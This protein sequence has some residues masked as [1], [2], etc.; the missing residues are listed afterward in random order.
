MNQNYIYIGGTQSAP[1]IS[2]TNE[3]LL[4]VNVNMNIDAIGNELAIDTLQFD[5]S[6]DDSSRRLRD[7]QYGTPIWYY[8]GADIVG[9]FYFKNIERI[10]TTSYRIDAVSVIGLLEYERHYGGFYVNKNVKEAVTEAIIND[11]LTVGEAQPCG[12]LQSNGNTPNTPLLPGCVGANA[13]VS[14][15]C[16][17]VRIKFQLD[18]VPETSASIPIWFLYSD[19]YNGE[20]ESDTQFSSYGIR[21]QR[22]GSNIWLYLSSNYFSWSPSLSDPYYD[23]ST[24]ASIGDLFEITFQPSAKKIYIIRNGAEPQII[25]ISWTIPNRIVPIYFLVG[26]EYRPATGFVPYTTNS[27]LKY[28]LYGIEYLSEDLLT[29]YAKFEP[30]A[31]LLGNAYVYDSIG[32]RVVEATGFSPSAITGRSHTF[33]EYASTDGTGTNAEFRT[34]YKGESVASSGCNTAFYLKFK[35]NA[36]TSE[37]PMAFQTVWKNVFIIPTNAQADEYRYYDAGVLLMRSSS[38]S[39]FSA[40]VYGTLRDVYNGPIIYLNGLS[41]GDVVEVAVYPKFG[42]AF[43]LV[44]GIVSYNESFTPVQS[45]D[46]ILPMYSLYGVNDDWNSN[47][48]SIETTPQG[49][50]GQFRPPKYSLYRLCF[51]DHDDSR[52]ASVEVQPDDTIYFDIE[53]AE[54]SL[55]GQYFHDKV[56]GEYF[57]TDYTAGGEITGHEDNTS[58]YEKVATSIVWQDGVDALT[59]SGWIPAGTKRATLHQILFALN[60]NL[61]KSGT[62]DIIIGRLPSSVNKTISD[63]DIYDS[64]S[65]E[66]VKKPKKIELTENAYTAPSSSADE[67][68]VFDN[69]A[70]TTP[71]GR[72]IAEFSSAPIYGTPTGSGLT[73][74]T[75]NA[76]AALV[77]GKGTIR[78]KTY[79]RSTRVITEEVGTRPDGDTVSVTDATLVTFLNSANVMAKLK[80]YYANN[81]Y[82]IKNAIVG[83]GELVG[84]KYTL[85]TPFGETDDAY[86]ISANIVGSGVSKINA[87]FLAG[88]TP[89]ES[90]GTYTNVV[91]LTG[92]GTWEVPSGTEQIH[93]VLIGG[94]RGGDSGFAGEDGDKCWEWRSANVAEGGKKGANGTGGKIYEVDIDVSSTSWSYS[95]G[96]GGSGGGTS[97]SNE[98]NNP[99]TNGTAS[100]FSQGG[101]SYSSDSGSSNEQGYTDPLTGKIYAGQMPKNVDGGNGGYT[102]FTSNGS[103]PSESQCHFNSPENVTNPL[104]GFVYFGGNTSVYYRDESEYDPSGYNVRVG[105]S[106]GGAALNE[107]G[108][109]GNTW[110]NMYGGNGADATWVPPA[111]TD[112]Q[113]E[114]YGYGG[115]GGAGGGGGGSTG[116]NGVFEGID[117][118]WLA[119][120][121]YPGTGGYGGRGGNGGNGCILVYW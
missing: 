115:M 99:G 7:L 117:E 41:A 51:F 38:S 116:F 71:E 82:K 48:H 76:N 21:V 15:K 20:S 27:G 54:D 84:R 96:L 67:T 69:S 63:D 44:N 36:P 72:Y 68:T 26:G 118:E 102:T 119:R 18:E 100:T 79:T 98:T 95:C 33:Y 13:T 61:Y 74:Y 46:R 104:S 56:S 87:V 49:P 34:G 30:Y 66:D 80:A 19:R 1:E 58:I 114:F 92:S 8:V 4:N 120:Y 29:T 17:S 24:G 110:R 111:P 6:Y 106:G 90:G 32:D 88:Y 12:Y 52:T 108:E 59:F 57:T 10:G 103:R 53:A 11:S 75:Y 28:K 3:Q 2:F 23:V 113:S 97:S 101:T 93:V 40:F 45:Y 64:G 42:K 81:A 31:D 16:T 73:I 105:G 35:V 86:L 78:A 62:G 5:V 50:D 65:T 91:V 9:K 77:S 85:K 22:S 47:T 55:G 112:Y 14:G 83:N 109:D 39:S 37:W 25:N 121:C 89:V 70:I 43:G 107:N 60:L 94:G